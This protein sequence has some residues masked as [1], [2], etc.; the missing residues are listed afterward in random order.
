LRRAFRRW[1]CRFTMGCLRKC[2]MTDG[3]VA[4]KRVKF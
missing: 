2:E 3:G 1:I 4:A